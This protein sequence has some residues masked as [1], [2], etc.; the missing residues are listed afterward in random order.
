MMLMFIVVIRPSHIFP[1]NFWLLYKNVSSDLKD[2]ISTHFMISLNFCS[3]FFLT[4]N[5][6]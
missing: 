2:T 6:L 1:F 3:P 4:G 5:M